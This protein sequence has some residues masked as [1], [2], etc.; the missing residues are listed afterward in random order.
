MTGDGGL[1][2]CPCCGRKASIAVYG[3]YYSVLCE[4]CGLETAHRPSKKEAVALWN[5]RA[6]ELLHDAILEHQMRG[7]SREECLNA[8]GRNKGDREIMAKVRAIG[9]CASCAYDDGVWDYPC[10]GCLRSPVA[11]LPDHYRRER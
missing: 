10:D 9:T 4:N 3:D 2:A 6:Y 1:K 7:Y 5:R 11:Q 8:L